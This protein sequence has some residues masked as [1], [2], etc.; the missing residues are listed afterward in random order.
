MKVSNGVTRSVLITNLKKILLESYPQCAMSFFIP[1]V[2]ALDKNVNFDVSHHHLFD[3]IDRKE[4][5]KVPMSRQTT[6][7]VE[8]EGVSQITILLHKPYLVKVNTKG[9]GG[10]KIPKILTTWFMDDP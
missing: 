10:S 2:K 8:G 7:S 4:W 9:G 5:S 6:W 1:K 3:M